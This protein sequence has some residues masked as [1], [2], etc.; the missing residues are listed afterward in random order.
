MGNW[1]IAVA[2]V[3]ISGLIRRFTSARVVAILLGHFLFVVAGFSQSFAQAPSDMGS[4][5]GPYFQIRG[6]DTSGN[7]ID[8]LIYRFGFLCLD[9]LRIYDDGK[10]R[11]VERE[12]AAFVN[13]LPHNRK[14][15]TEALTALGATC[16]DSSEK[17]I[18]CLYRKRARTFGW[19]TGNRLH[20]SSP[21]TSLSSIS[22]CRMTVSRLRRRSTSTKHTSESN[23]SQI[24]E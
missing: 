22:R 20:G 17:P 24:A 11:R 4:Y 1:T 13:S 23:S 19:I 8:K 16:I 9:E 10:P 7:P 15:V 21:T 12:L 2:Q 3:P 14:D 6:L 18:D 5:S